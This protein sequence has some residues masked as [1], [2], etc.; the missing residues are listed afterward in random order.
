M[1]TKRLKNTRR[2][3]SAKDAENI[4]SKKRKKRKTDPVSGVLAAGKRFLDSCRNRIKGLKSRRPHQSMKLTKRRDYERSLKMP[5]YIAF[6]KEVFLMMWRNR[7]IFLCLILVALIANIVLVGIMSQDMYTSLADALNETGSNVASGE[8]GQVG[9]AA[10]LLLST[11][12][13]GGLNT[14]PT[15]VQ[16]VLGVLIFVI[17]WLVVVWILRNV[18]AKN[19]VRMRDGLYNACA[20]IVPTVLILIIMFIQAIPAMIAFIVYSA[21]V[22]TDFLSNPFYAILFWMF[23]GALTLLS[24]YL[25]V[26]TMFALIV[27]T[28]PGMYPMKAMKIA[29]DLTIGR[30]VRILLRVIW[31]ALV[32]V[33]VWAVVM[34]PVILFDSWIKGVWEALEDLP[35]VPIALQLMTSVTVVFFTTYMYLFYRK[36]IDDGSSP[37]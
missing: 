20:P 5:G 30:R 1:S 7:R 26:S 18:I 10:L 3:K 35:I 16:T 34:I 17:M 9:K 2:N 37:A 24:L 27:V 28:I 14:S 6:T 31:M 21:A 15:E 36:T 33:L 23:A 12:T 25:V 29:G 13:T 22:A 4:G 8:L 19:K 32:V 11:A